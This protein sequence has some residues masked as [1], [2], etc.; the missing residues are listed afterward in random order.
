MM[1]RVDGEVHFLQ[2]PMD[3]IH[4]VLKYVKELNDKKMNELFTDDD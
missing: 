2:E 4:D 1:Y 3:E